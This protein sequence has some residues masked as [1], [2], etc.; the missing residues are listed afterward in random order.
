MP[1]R[2]HS[3]YSTPAAIVVNCQDKPIV[4]VL[5][6]LC[7]STRY[8]RKWTSIIQDRR[9]ICSIYPRLGHV[10]VRWMNKRRAGMPPTDRTSQTN[11]SVRDYRYCL[12]PPPPCQVNKLR[13]YLYYIY[14]GIFDAVGI[15]TCARAGP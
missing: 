4:C 13:K 9:Y 5:T 12:I 11:L 15:N 10:V 14:W 8:T 7:T 2:Y 1:C 6:C 3:V